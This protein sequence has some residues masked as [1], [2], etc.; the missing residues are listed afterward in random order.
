[1]VSP[2]WHKHVHPHGPLQ[3]IAGNTWQVTGSL[4]KGHVPRNMVVHRMPNGGLWLH[5]VIALDEKRMAELV[6]LGRPEILVVPSGLHRLDA[7][8]Y[9]ER[10]PPLQVLCPAASRGEVA[11]K[12][13]VDGI[14]EE[15][16][17]ARGILV[18]RADGLKD[19][20]LAYVLS[21]PEGKVLVV[22]DMLF[23]LPRLPGIDG[24]LLHW[25]GSTGFFGITVIGRLFLL[26]NKRRFAEWLTQMSGMPGLYAISVAHGDAVVGNAGEALRGARARLGV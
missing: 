19:T 15:V 1:M 17:P 14:C 7:A 22:T 26:K 10:F 5:S 11:K 8:V 18:I 20:E 21:A 12:V 23:N 24:W 13:A 9:K 3:Q 2:N 4:S 25:I 16:L 6:A